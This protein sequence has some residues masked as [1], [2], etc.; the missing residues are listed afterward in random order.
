MQTQTAKD[1]LCL[2]DLRPLQCQIYPVFVEGDTVML[3]NDLPGCV[4]PWS[5]GDVD[6]DTEQA[7]YDR[8]K[9][10]E[11]EHIEMVREWNRR[12]LEE[13]AT[14]CFEEFCTYLLNHCGTQEDAP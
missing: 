8:F 14:R 5:Y 12:I 1:Q 13:G 9:A 11:T 10:F 4:R 6:L 2:H 7:R 3:I